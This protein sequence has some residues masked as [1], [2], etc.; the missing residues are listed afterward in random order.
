MKRSAAL[1]LPVSIVLLH[2]ATTAPTATPT[3]ALPPSTAV[4]PVAVTVPA[5]PAASLR[6][7]RFPAGEGTTLVQEQ[8]SHA[9]IDIGVRDPHVSASSRVNLAEKI[10]GVKATTDGN[11]AV[12]YGLMARNASG[13]FGCFELRIGTFTSQQPS[14]NAHCGLPY[15]SQNLAGS[16]S[17][18][19]ARLTVG[20]LREAVAAFPTDRLALARLGP[21]DITTPAGER[22][23]F[24]LG[25]RSEDAPVSCFVLHVRGDAMAIET[26][27]LSDCGVIWPPPASAFERGA[28]F[29]ALSLD[30]EVAKCTKCSAREVC[31]VEQRAPRAAATRVKDGMISA[32]YSDGRSA[33]V[34]LASSCVALPP[35]CAAATSS[36]WSSATSPGHMAPPVPALSHVPP[37]TMGPC[38]A[39]ARGYSLSTGTATTPAHATCM[40]YSD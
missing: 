31:V 34:T 18:P 22:S 33:D 20:R 1:L 3:V 15:V 12:F 37:F 29:P 36:C 30:D 11:D 9:F 14:D 6:A 7:A 27:A 32:S 25:G 2:C 17:G 35:G 16:Y 13:P 4:P 39:D 19:G 8:L 28:V 5:T 21:A 24:G 40:R 38:G 26:A 10:L 23:Y